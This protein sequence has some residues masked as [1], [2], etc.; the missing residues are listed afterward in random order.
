MKLKLLLFSICLLTVSG[1]DG[2]LPISWTVLLT[3]I[4]VAISQTL[5]ENEANKK[6][7]KLK[8]RNMKKK[9][10]T[11]MMYCNH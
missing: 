8:G 10:L 11:Q 7:R 3:G 9:L 6:R 4:G 1:C 2:A 5:K